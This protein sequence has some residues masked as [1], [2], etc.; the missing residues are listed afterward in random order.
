LTFFLADNSIYSGQ[1]NYFVIPGQAGSA[2]GY[3]KYIA[4]LP[5]SYYLLLVPAVLGGMLGAFILAHTTNHTFQ[6]I[7]PWFMLFATILLAVQPKIH[8]WLYSRTAKKLQKRYRS[9]FF[10]FI[11]L[12]MF[13]LSIYGGYFGAGYGI[14]LLAFLGLSKLTNIHQMNGLKNLASVSINVTIVVYFIFVGLIAWSVLPPL[15]LGS[16]LGGWFGATYSTKLPTKTIWRAIVIVGILVSATLF[17]KQY[18]L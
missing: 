1:Q 15:L 11:F 17:I 14:V 9:I 13:L 6:Y 18:Y 4:K 8:K 3:R 5:P 16:V 7:V 2:F 10:G 12:I